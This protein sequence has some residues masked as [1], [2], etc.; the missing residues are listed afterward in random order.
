M[1]LGLLFILAGTLHF[2]VPAYYLRIIP[3]FLPHGLVLVY[4]SGVAEVLGGSGVLSRRWR[5]AAGLGLISLLVAVF[6]ANVQ[7]LLLAQRSGAPMWQQVLLWLRLPLQ[8]ALISWVWVVTR[9]GLGRAD[10]YPAMG[11][12]RDAG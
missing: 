6:P 12:E 11:A 4:L 1:P 7:M 5:R 10:P 2:L 3:P 8:G 9:P